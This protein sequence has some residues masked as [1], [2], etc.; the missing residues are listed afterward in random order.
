M[1]D[2]NSSASTRLPALLEPVALVLLS[3]AT[4][5]TAW[6]SYQAAVWGGVSQRAM[7]QSAAASRRAV[8]DQLQASQMAV[9]DV[10][11]FSQYVNAHV[12]SNQPLADFYAERFRNEAKIAFQ[13]WIATDPFVNPEAPPHPFATNLYQPRLL[14]S[15]R[16]AD[17]ESLALWQRAGEA[18]R[19][20]RG[21]CWSRCFWR[22]RC[23]AAE[24]R[25]DSSP[26]WSGGRC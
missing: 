8:A 14:E 21:T 20:S 22:P 19:V 5:G 24:R 1:A 25:R 13:A 17:A 15:A 9:L 3:L 2:N 11:L 10:M 16:T 23:S 12:S 18:G 7:N 4:V 26:P 6:C